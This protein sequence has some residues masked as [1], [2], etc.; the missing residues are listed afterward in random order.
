[1]SPY[2]IVKR[3]AMLKFICALGPLFIALSAFAADIVGRVT[4]V[5]GDTLE[6]H[7]Q[8]I[9]LWGIDA[10]ESNQLC[11]GSDSLHYRCGAKAAN[12]LDAFI[13]GRPASCTP[14]SQDRYRRTVA[15]CSV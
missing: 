6:M 9:R 15:S 11:R 12:D 10:P 1:M 14:L 8:R 7:G 13:S 3:R 4:V 2:L 5:D